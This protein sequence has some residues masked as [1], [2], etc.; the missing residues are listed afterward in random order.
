[1]SKLKKIFY[2]LHLKLVM[3]QIY[4]I[5]YINTVDIFNLL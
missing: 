4:K 2:N 1:M 3:K 5:K